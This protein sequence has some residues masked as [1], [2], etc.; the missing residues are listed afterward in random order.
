LWTEPEVTGGAVI[1]V[2]AGRLPGGMA[3]PPQ[4]H[5]AMRHYTYK[6][7]RRLARATCVALVAVAGATAVVPGAA[8]AATGL[9]SWTGTKTSSW[10]SKLPGRLGQVGWKLP[11]TGQPQP[12]KP[13]AGGGGTTTPPSG[14]SG[15]A[16]GT[17]ASFSGNYTSSAGSRAYRG[18]VPS[19]YEKGKAMPLV[20]VLHGCTQS[21][22]VIRQLT[23][24]DQ[25]AEA[26]GFIAV[27]PEQPSSANQQSCWNFFQDAHTHRGSGEP[28]MIAG[29][30]DW[31]KQHYTVDP[32]KTY[33]AGLSAGGAMASVMGAT[34]PD[35][36]AAI[37]V[38]SGC[39]YGATAACAGYQSTDPAKAA[40]AAYAAMGS[41]ARPMPVIAFQGD[42][43]TTVPPVNGDQLVEQWRLTA[44]L[45]DDATANGSFA[46][47]PA[48]TTEGQV[49]NG[50]SY[51][52]R[53]YNDS[54]GKQFVEYWTVHGMPHAWSGGCSCQ[55]Y[56]DPTGPDETAAMYAFFMSHPMP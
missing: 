10:W 47:S 12:P 6:R 31:V 3:E 21:A 38:G 43:D 50:R 33:V 53:D 35:V 11:G 16:T 49:P 55:K 48:T 56:S 25:L 22:D 13:P 19:T 34:Y 41:Y 14:G 17:G 5:E 27:F 54:S 44:D 4:T 8:G 37:G 7:T 2:A 23:R 30:T 26:K 42:K 20:V 28:A 52:I 1:S 46:S 9:P 40:Q 32:A 39:E 18:Y 45:A 29:I 15:G 24:F 36:F 51:T